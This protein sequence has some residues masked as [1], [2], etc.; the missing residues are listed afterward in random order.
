MNTFSHSL[1]ENCETRIYVSPLLLSIIQKL[2]LTLIL[3]KTITCIK[4][5]LIALFLFCDLK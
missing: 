1:L 5:H 4:K 3:L 2:K